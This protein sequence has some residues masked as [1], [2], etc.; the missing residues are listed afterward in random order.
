MITKKWL[1]II[2]FIF[3][4]VF[5]VFLLTMRNINTKR[6]NVSPNSVIELDEH[7]D[8]LSLLVPDWQIKT[9]SDQ[10]VYST[11]LLVSASQANSGIYVPRTKNAELIINNSTKNIFND[12]SR[13]IYLIMPQAKDQRILIEIHT[14]IKPTD[15]W[16]SVELYVGKI[17]S[18]LAA[19]QRE[20]KLRF[21]IVGLSF[22]IILLSISLYTHKPNEKYL[23]PLALLA[24]STLGYILL[25]VFPSLKENFWTNFL[26][27]G[28]I[29][30]P[31]LSS[32]TSHLIYQLGFPLFLG[33]LNF[34]LIKNFVSVKIFKIDYYY[35]ILIVALIMSI[36]IGSLQDAF[37]PQILRVFIHLLES[38]VIIKGDYQNK[39][40][41]FILMVGSIGT[42]SLNI[43]ITGIFMD[44]IPH[45]D[46]DLLFRIGGV[47]ASFYAIAITIA[48]TGIFARKYAESEV[49]RE[50]LDNLNLNLHKEVNERTNS[51]KLAYESLEKEQQQKDIFTTNMVHS[52][53]TPLFAIAGY[54]DMAQEALQSSPNKVIHFINLVNTNAD[55]VVKL[56]DN[57]FLALRL[58][59]KKITFMI[60]KMDLSTCLE[61]I[62]NTTLPQTKSKN[63]YFYQKVPKEPFFIECDLYYLTLAI[64]NIVDNAVRH[65]PIGGEIKLELTDLGQEIQISVKD[66]GEGIPEKIIQQIFERYYSYRNAGNL[67]SGLGLSISKDVI[68]ALHGQIN[69][70]SVLGEGTEFVISLPKVTDI[71]YIGN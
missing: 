24:Y 45:G 23:L 25:G 65:T 29:K 36:F 63:I 64:Q 71:E 68:S 35:Y 69:V 33:F 56:V 19:S 46:I 11:E 41:T 21:F 37:F 30:L 67:S 20:S 54:A 42:T 31:F 44:I 14:Q 58:D 9:T 66:N 70:K 27:L 59:N 47:Y 52:L 18:I 28:S 43:F 62:Y 61:Q 2:F 26:L 15:E 53:K 13:Y 40:D 16:S 7:N 12:Q 3:G 57:L 60:E 6:I 10:K 48:V 50:E 5:I 49:L 8:Q 22:T 1:R 34:L 17:D 39:S 51:L 55:F 32:E 4:V 38:I